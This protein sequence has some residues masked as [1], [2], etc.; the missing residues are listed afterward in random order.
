MSN[1]CMRRP[2][3]FHV[4]SAVRFWAI[5]NI[6]EGGRQTPPPV[7]RGLKHGRGK[8]KYII[9]L[10]RDGKRL[11]RTMTR[12]EEGRTEDG[13][14]TSGIISCPWRIASVHW[15]GHKVGCRLRAAKKERLLSLFTVNYMARARMVQALTLQLLWASVQRHHCRITTQCASYI[16]SMA[17]CY[18]VP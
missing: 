5:A 1:C 2:A 17:A 15:C 4:D 12:T 13:M 3:K 10:Q 6:R 14:Q 9:S 7:K 8:V 18:I 16:P 11:T